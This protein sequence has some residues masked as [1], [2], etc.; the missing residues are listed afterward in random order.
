MVDNKK[1]HARLL[2]LPACCNYWV[3]ADNSKNFSGIQSHLK[4]QTWISN[5]AMLHSFCV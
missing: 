2:I 3:K 5:L 4:I 1:Y